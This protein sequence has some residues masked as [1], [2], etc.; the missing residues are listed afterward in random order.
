MSKHVQTD[1]PTDA[2]LKGNP[3]IGTSKGQTAAQMRRGDVD[4][5]MGENTVEGDLGND[6]TP[7]GGIQKQDSTTRK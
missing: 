5:T 2:D 3:G 4:D 1:K 7:Q 6:T